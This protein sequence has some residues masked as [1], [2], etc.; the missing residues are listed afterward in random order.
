[1]KPKFS[2]Q[3][4]EKYENINFMAICPVGVELLNADRGIDGQKGSR[5]T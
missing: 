1:M 5:P 4:F 2:W 3:I